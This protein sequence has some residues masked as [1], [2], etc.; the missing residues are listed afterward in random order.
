MLCQRIYI[1]EMCDIFPGFRIERIKQG[2]SVCT[3]FADVILFGI[4]LS[5]LSSN[6]K[7]ARNSIFILSMYH[8][9]FELC[10]R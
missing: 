3:Y 4:S 5:I 6:R 7:Y 9:V 10:S 8:H 1:K 2:S